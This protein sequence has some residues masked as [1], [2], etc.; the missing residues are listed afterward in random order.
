MQYL[1]NRMR[2]N[3]FLIGSW[4]TLPNNSIAEI[5]SKAGFDWLA[6]DLE[7]SSITIKDAEEL[8]RVI[9]LCNV[10]PFV[11][12]T[13][14]NKN[15]TKRILDAGARGVIVPMVN[16]PNDIQEIVDYLKYPPLG[17]RSVGLARAQGYGNNFKDYLKIEKK[18]ITLIIQIEHIDAVNNIDNI[19]S[20]K[21]IDGYLIGPYD[22]S[23]SLGIPGEFNNPVYTRAVK[24]INEAALKFNLTSGI[25]VVEPD[26]GLL[27][28]AIK[29]N[30]KFIAYSLD[31]RMLDVMSRQALDKIKKN[32]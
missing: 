28:K 1:K 32:K 29:E 26:I 2:N 15:Q 13:S 16:S 6:I 19:F 3:N 12:L 24:K 30:Y 31:I 7:H 17:S 18:E 9:D 22:L 25:H 14:I 11:R 4:I 10:F 5:M 27:K 21:Y 23:M 20:S 8:I